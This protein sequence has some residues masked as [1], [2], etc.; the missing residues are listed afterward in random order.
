MRF[1]HTG[2]AIGSFLYSAGGFKLPFIVVGSFGVF[3]ACG[4][5]FIIPDLKKAKRIKKVGE[6]NNLYT[7]A[8]Q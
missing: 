5:F 1:P 8:T 7:L 3:V 6:I 2:P 4:L